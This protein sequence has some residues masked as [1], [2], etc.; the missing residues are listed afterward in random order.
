MCEESV[1]GLTTKPSMCL[2]A[3]DQC[4][5]LGHMVENGIVQ[6]M[7]SKVEAVQCWVVFEA[8]CMVSVIVMI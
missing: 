8:F 2:F 4:V 6:P 3:M 5:Y 1:A 7:V